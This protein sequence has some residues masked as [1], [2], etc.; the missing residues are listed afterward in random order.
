MTKTIRITLSAI[1]LFIMAFV[2]YQKVYLPK[3]TYESYRPKKGSTSVTV[4]G[5]GELSAERIYPVGTPT[6]GR[7]LSIETDQGH[8]IKKGELIATLDPVDLQSRLKGAKIA[9]KRAKLDIETARDEFRIS[10]T[11]AALAQSTYSKDYEVYRS[12]GISELAYQKSRTEMLTAKAQVDIAQSKIT[13]L[14]VHLLELKETIVGLEQK[15]GQ[16]TILSPTD[17][18]VIERSVEKGQSIPPAFT[19]VKIVDPQTLWIKA[20]VDER[21]SGKVKRGQR[22][23]ITLRSHEKMPLEGVVKRIA[24]VSDP[25][26]EE[27]EIDIGFVKIPE[28]FYIN[29]QAEVSI[30][31]ET[32]GGLYKIPLALI[33]TYKDGKGIWTVRDGKA[34]FVK[35]SVVAKDGKYAG[36][37]KGVTK[38]TKILVPDMK[39]KPLFEGSSV[40]L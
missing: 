6:G 15:I 29:E 33:V 18:Y 1:I 30:E 23:I 17:G 34:H 14:E 24:A 31:I 7:I 9:L 38:E 3:S 32:F 10:Q 28:P 40:S 12:K 20:W 37:G 25:V 35:I 8:W 13:S 39:K 5:I 27:R 36:V 16:L 22:A 21:I 2:F 26:T 4:F 19:L 11:Q